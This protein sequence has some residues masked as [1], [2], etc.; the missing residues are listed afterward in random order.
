MKR[1]VLGAIALLLLAGVA[2]RAGE[3]LGIEVKEHVLDN[4]LKILMVERHGIPTVS[5]NVRFRVGS[6]DERVGMTGVAHILE[7]ML[8]KGTPKLGTKDYEKEKPLLDEIERLYLSMRALTGSIPVATWARLRD[9]EAAADTDEAKAAARAKILDEGQLMTLARIRKMKTEFDAVREKAR[10]YV[11]EEEDW[12]L[13]ER[14]GARGLN[15]ATGQDSTAYFYSLPKNRIE[16][17]HL[18]ES[19]RMRYPVLREFYTER[20]VIM[21]E[22]RMRVDNSLSGAL[23]ET[24]YGTAFLAHSYRW[25]PIGWMSDISRVARSE[26]E[27]FFR[28]YY[29][30]NRAV[31][32]VVGDFEPAAMIKLF[33]TYWGDIPRQ[34]DPEE[35]RT[36]EPPQNGARRAVVKFPARVQVVVQAYHRPACGHPDFY[37]LDLISG[38]LN[39]GR[40]SRLHKNLVKTQIAAQ[41]FAQ[42]QDTRYP[43]LFVIGAVPLQAPP[44]IMRSVDDCEKA[45]AKEIERLQKEPVPAAELRKV[46]DGI[47]AGFI[48]GLRTNAGLAATLTSTEAVISWHYYETY[49]DRI[50]KVT[51]ADIQ[52]V[53]KEYFRDS[54]RTTVVLKPDFS[55]TRRSARAGE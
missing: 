39:A 37:A 4:G 1:V 14:N 15:A 46:I 5:F 26:V 25:M 52:R 33:E 28:T 36:V 21:E 8:F 20:K 7:H 24:A 19:G 44:M 3:R 31:V 2:A 45:I 22:R 50:A 51:P 48:R 42:N 12:T 27:E 49:L 29:A 16:L 41:A 30:P 6:V 34:P 32:A 54:N 13:L 43:H 10:E 18:V 40:T 47:E 53:A 38:L 55:G 11:V 23:F 35:P 9:A 17:F